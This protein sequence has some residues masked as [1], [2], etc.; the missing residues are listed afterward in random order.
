LDGNDCNG[1]CGGGAVEDACGFCVGNDSIVPGQSWMVNI[2]ATTV[3]FDNTRA[4]DSAQ[5]GASIYAEDGYNNENIIEANCN[6]C[7]IDI[8]ESCGLADSLCFY[9]PHDEW[10]SESDSIFTSGYNFDRD[11]RGNNLRTLFIDG[12]DWDGEI[13]S[14]LSESVLIDSLILDF[15]F[16]QGIESCMITVTLNYGEEYDVQNNHLGIEIG[17]NENINLTFNISNICFSEF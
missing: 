13:S 2:N 10:E 17:S 1:E 15:T 14:F 5:I 12:I 7:Y 8:P 11:I 16:I 4:S 6:G 9:F 3:F